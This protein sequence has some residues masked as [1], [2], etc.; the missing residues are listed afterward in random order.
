MQQQIDELRA[1]VG[2]A[3]GQAPYPVAST[4]TAPAP[5]ASSGVEAPKAEEPPST[6]GREEEHPPQPDPRP[7]E[8]ASM[9]AHVSPAIRGRFERNQQSQ[10][11]A[12]KAD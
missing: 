12:T 4:P 5:T 8:V 6:A 3:G 7:S 10:G 9:L 2:Q 1:M 11:S